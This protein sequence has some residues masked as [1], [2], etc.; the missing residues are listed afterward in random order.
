MNFHFSHASFLLCVFPP[1][2]LPWRGDGAVHRM[3]ACMPILIEALSGGEGCHS[4]QCKQAPQSLPVCSSFL[5]SCGL[6]FSSFGC[7]HCSWLPAASGFPSFSSPLQSSPPASASMV[8]PEK[9]DAQVHGCLVGPVSTCEPNSIC[10]GLEGS[11][12]QAG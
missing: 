5:C 6:F 2:P 9:P 10:S 1:R 7:A 12:S 4:G 3:P 8:R 11:V